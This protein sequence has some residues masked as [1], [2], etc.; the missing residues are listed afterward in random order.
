MVDAVPLRAD[1][2][3]VKPD[4]AIISREEVEIAFLLILGRLPESETVIAAHQLPTVND[5]RLVLLK[6]KEFAEKYK[7]IREAKAGPSGSMS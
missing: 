5:L 2:I 7:V 3:D 4:S 6:S 1:L